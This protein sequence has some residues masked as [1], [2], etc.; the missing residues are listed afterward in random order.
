M[1]KQTAMLMIY[2]LIGICLLLTGCGGGGD[3]DNNQNVNLDFLGK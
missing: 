3:E 2:F 1:K